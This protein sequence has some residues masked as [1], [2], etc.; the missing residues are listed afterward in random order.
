MTKLLTAARRLLSRW[1][2]DPDQYWSL[3]RISLI[4]DFRRQS[5]LQGGGSAQSALAMT[6]VVYGLF[7]LLLALLSFRS[8]TPFY[9]S[10][11]FLSYGM[12][13]IAFIILSEFGATIINPDDYEILGHRPISSRTYFLAKLSNLLFYIVLIGSSLNFFPALLGAF[14]DSSSGLFPL[15]YFPAALLASLFSAVLVVLFYGV[16]LRAIPY[17]RFKDALVYL[18]IAFSFLIFFGYQL[19]ARAMPYL[20][21]NSD[22]TFQRALMLIPPGWFAGLV[23]LGLGQWQRDYVLWAGWGLLATG[24][25]A[26]ASVRSFSLDYA[27]YLAHVRARRAASG[28]KRPSVRRRLVRPLERL[29]LK[30]P[31]ERA[32]FYFVRQMLRRNRILKLRLYPA[33]GF[34]VAYLAIGVWENTMSDPYS[35]TQRLPWAAFFLNMVGPLLVLNFHALLPYSEEH[36]AAWLF[37]AAPVRDLRGIF[38]GAKKALL[39]S[40]LGPLFVL[41]GIVLS[42]FWTPSHAFLHATFGFL[43]SYLFLGIVFLFYRGG[44]PFSQEPIKSVQTGQMVL[45]FSALPLMGALFFLQYVFSKNPGGLLGVMGGFLLVGWLLN[46]IA[47][48]KA[49]RATRRRYER[50]GGTFED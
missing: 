29:F 27:L 10:L 9:Y 25:L 16:L 26:T 34:P 2:I 38:T 18:Q 39:V 44:F 21:R 35:S 50:E 24:I 14:S 46:R 12:A 41:L 8:L 15:V 6:C 42:W 7:S 31:E 49:A 45:G 36:A 32:A 3:L 4:L 13:M 40:L 19:I 37:R 23:Q 17:E 48:R 1:G 43:M 22:P 28:P 47:D 33:L 11:L 5:P 20:E 30:S